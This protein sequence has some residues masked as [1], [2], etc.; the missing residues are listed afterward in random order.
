MTEKDNIITCAYCGG[1]GKFEQR[2]TYESYK[3]RQDI[4]IEIKHGTTCPVC[5]GKGKFLNVKNAA[6]CKRCR[7]S[8]R[9]ENGKMCPTCGGK[10]RVILDNI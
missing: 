4:A 7:A 1:A 8:G 9:I 10:G 3:G 6:S 5:K 2:P